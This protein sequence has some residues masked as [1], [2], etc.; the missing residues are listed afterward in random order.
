M[1]AS[2]LRAIRHMALSIAD[3]CAALLEIVDAAMPTDP[4]AA[5]PG[6]KQEPAPD[7][8]IA[9]SEGLP[10]MLG[11]HRQKAT[12][13]AAAPVTGTDAGKASD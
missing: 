1:R 7:A 13:E 9:A 3:Q 2:E 11:S 5:D 6:V 8:V 10:P 12:A 4:A